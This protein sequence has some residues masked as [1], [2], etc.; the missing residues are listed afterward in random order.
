VT[1]LDGVMSGWRTDSELAVLNEGPRSTPLPVSVDLLEAIEAAIAI[2]EQTAGAYDPTVEP[3]IEVYDLRGDGRRPSVA[4]LR[5]ALAAVDY[6]QVLTDTSAR[7]VEQASPG[8]ALDLGGIGK[9]IALDHMVEIFER[10]GVRAALINF[11]GQITTVGE[12]VAGEPWSVEIAD[13]QDRDL[14]VMQLDVRDASIATSSQSERRL[15]V[16]DVVIGHVLDPRTGEPVPDWGSVTVIA[17]SGARADAMSTALFVMGPEEARR[18]AAAQPDL[19]AIILEKDRS[20]ADTPPRLS[21]AGSHPGLLALG[22]PAAPSPP[23][24]LAQAGGDRETPPSNAE[25]ARRI[26]ILSS[27]LEDMQLGEIADAMQPAYGL[28][29]AASKVYHVP[30]GVSVGGY[31]EMLYE[32][33]AQNREDD[34][35]A[36]KTDQFDFLRNVFYLG[37]KFTDAI[38]FNSEIEFE[39]AST[40][41]SGSVSV[42]FAYIDFMYHRQHGI[43]GGMVLIPSGFINELHEPPTFLGARRPE[44]EQKIIPSTWRGNGAGAFGQSSSGISYRAYVVEGLDGSKFSDSSGVRGGRQKGSKAKVDHF[45]VVARGDYEHPVGLL[46]GGSVYSGGSAQGLVDTLGNEFTARTTIVEVHGQFRRQGF[47][48]RVLWA[49]STIDEVEQLNQVVYPAGDRTLG[50]KGVGWYI[51]VGYDVLYVAAPASGLQL[52]PYVRYEAL[53]TQADVPTG[54]TANPANDQTIT[55][56]GASFYPHEQVVIKGDYQVRRNEAKTGVNQ[57]NL[58]LGFMY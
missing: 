11:G 31:G 37:Y 7:S 40:S 43:R 48:T 58:A 8:A 26:D 5:D 28:G 3:L 24:L 25:L 1:R 13:P 54:F 56:V 41:K 52:I 27:E 16:D 38:I 44:V 2:A 57:F 32:S 21:I 49:Q 14:A 9:G 33:F 30:Q 36:G 35:L 55:T 17:D 22:P 53:N 10:S 47:Q 46:V 19:A 12:P 15:I 29:P 18:F 51:D 42:E 6:R 4:A 50:E 20:A 34:E 45:G 39:H 23:D